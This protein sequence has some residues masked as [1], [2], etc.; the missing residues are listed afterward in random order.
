MRDMPPIAEPIQMT[1][2]DVAA[3]RVIIDRRERAEQAARAAFHRA[4]NP[5]D[6]AEYAGE[7]DIF[8]SPPI[9]ERPAKHS[10]PTTMNRGLG[11]PEE[12]DEHE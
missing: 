4:E 7:G 2:A 12:S 5:R 9:V 10:T 3:H 8:A 11:V 6:L 1:D